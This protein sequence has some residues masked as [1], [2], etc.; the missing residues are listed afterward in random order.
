ML[1][2][3]TWLTQVLQ[4]QALTLPRP[5]STLSTCVQRP[6]QVGCPPRATQYPGAVAGVD[7]SVYV[8]VGV[9]PTGA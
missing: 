3:A 7:T 4:V 1:T 9:Q 2:V 6:W 8:S 5:G